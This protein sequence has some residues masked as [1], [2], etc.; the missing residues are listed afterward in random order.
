[1]GKTE[2]W[3]GSS[4]TA[5]CGPSRGATPA[6]FTSRPP[7]ASAGASAVDALVEERREGGEIFGDTSA[8]V[9]VLVAEPA[10]RR[11]QAL[12][13]PGPVMLVWWGDVD[14]H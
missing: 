11:L 1:V 10:T 13:R 12:R 5:L 4:V 7:R 2:G 14:D 3:R 8:I 9:P 6:L